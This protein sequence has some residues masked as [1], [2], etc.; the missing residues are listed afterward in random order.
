M[1]GL[2]HEL[3]PGRAVLMGALQIVSLG[4]DC[5]SQKLSTPFL[6]MQC[7]T[8]ARCSRSLYVFLLM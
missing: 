1:L 7:E 2:G 8:A 5:F 3:A 4:K 6:G